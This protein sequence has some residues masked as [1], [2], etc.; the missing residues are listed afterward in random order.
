[1]GEGHVIPIL[2]GSAEAAIALSSLLAERD[3]FL[4]PVR[5]P[6]IPAGTA[7]LRVTVTASLT[8]RHVDHLLDAFEGAGARL[9]T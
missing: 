3:V 6:T 1:M 5:P 9:A 7:R 4:P 8:D 2:V